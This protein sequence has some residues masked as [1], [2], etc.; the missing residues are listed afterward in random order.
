MSDTVLL[1]SVNLRDDVSS[2]GRLAHYRPTRR[3]LPIVRAVLGG[4]ATMAIAAYGS[5]K[6][7]AA[8]VG[9]LAVMNRVED[10]EIL[11]DLAARIEAVDPAIGA[12]A[13]ERVYG[14]G[15]GRAILLV[16]HVPDLAGAL[17]EA[18]GLPRRKG[19][20]AALTALSRLEG[21]DRVAIVWD[22]FGRHL[23]GIVNE[24]R[25]R[26]LDA[27]QRLA[28]WVVRAQG[29]FASLTLL[30]HQ[31]LLAYA[32][33]LN[34]TSRNE[35]RK[36]EGRFERI[37]FVEDS[38]ELYGLAADMVEAA[39][40]EGVRPPGMQTLLAMAKRVIGAGWFDGMTDTDQVASLLGRAY[41]LSAAALQVLPRLVARIGQ[42]ER[43]MF[44]FIG[45]AD[46]G[47]PV[48]M[49]EIYVGFSD[50]MRSDVGI[51]GVHRRWVEAETARSR[52][53]NDV[54]REALAAACLLQLGADGER[55]R[56]PRLS[57]E[58]AV[59][60]RGV[61]P[62]AASAAVGRLIERKLLLHRQLNDDVSIWHG[63]DLDLPGR[64]RE[65]RARRQ[66]GFDL[67]AFLH[68]H[69][70]PPFL[71]PTRHNLRFGT[72]RY[73]Q[74][75]YV[76]ASKIAAAANRMTEAQ[77][78]SEWGRVFFVLADTAEELA[79]ARRRVEAGWPDWPRALVA[80]PSE[81]ISVT[82]AVFE[83]DALLALQ[84][85]EFLR[86]EDPLVGQELV[87]LLAVARRQ[88]GV[89]MHRLTT[90]RPHSTE[91]WRDGVRLP[92]SVDRPAGVAAS[93][94][95]DA[96]YPETP[97]ILNDQLMRRRLSRQMETARVRVLTRI[98]ERSED[99][100]LGYRTE[101]LSSAEGSVFRTVLEATGLH[102]GEGD[103]GILATPDELE[104]PG[105]RGAWSRIH[106]FFTVP[107]RRSLADIV[108]MLSAPPIGMPDGVVPLLVVA[109]L[110]AFGRAVTLRTDGAYVADLLGFAA[111]RMFL[112]P[113]RTQVEVHTGGAALTDYL[114]ELAYVFSHERPGPLDEHV[115]FAADA[116]ATWRTSLSD[117][118]RRSRRHTDDGRQLLR[119][120]NEARD[121]AA[122]LVD[123]VPAAWGVRHRGGTYASTLRVIEKARNDIDRL[124]EG[125]VRD[126][127]EVVGEVLS[128][129]SN[130]DPVAGVQ[131]WAAC[132]D[133]EAF[134]LRED[135]TLI[136]KAVLR[137]ARDTLNG[138]YSAESLARAVSSVLLQRG[139][140]RWE[141]G[142]PA[143]MRRLLRECRMRIEDAA[144][145]VDEPGAALMP[146]IRGRIASL[147]EKLHRMSEQSDL[148]PMAVTGGTR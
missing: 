33:A 138:R 22:E 1:R 23:E 52:A 120:F 8:G 64:I 12:L 28:E 44:A 140:D 106:A 78:S 11:R 9:A 79:Q 72:T 69:Q 105:M 104:D 49:E 87:E 10:A 136:D 61:D 38:Q 39:R 20:D 137:T 119:L 85:D 5:G 127:V 15:R 132:F 32:S 24:G 121:P 81:P 63:A 4:G 143:Q 114:S 129:G 102:R 117:G 67:L 46:L 139:L 27:V 88:L 86:S 58:I 13:T 40:E 133:V 93:E 54:E 21:I 62:E 145:S 37:R 14:T 98:L 34:Q 65:E 83:V 116:V 92:L 19:I 73:L 128:F 68:T 134:L 42:N 107:G 35:W 122:L 41:P 55:R 43:S 59:A 31:D 82:E 84:H 89:M 144:L 7:L 126:A 95:L 141:D 108:A 53:E 77:P 94:L 47:R 131:A 91:W 45:S 113:G 76:R 118:V 124:V 60:S 147:E 125:Y 142:T 71:R 74:G 112:E 100:Q 50:A 70:P 2:P 16:G 18:L 66:E 109:G 90:D 26:E 56:L 110:K 130:A 101:E 25:S 57:L 80:L 17:L 103:R 75:Q 115:R 111:S 96:A 135:V 123:T 6:S 99:P 51:G 3:S 48:G 97:R 36:I 29:A 148:I 146:I 30:L